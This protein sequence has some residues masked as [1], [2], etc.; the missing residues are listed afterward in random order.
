[1]HYIKKLHLKSVPCHFGPR[2]NR[3]SVQISENETKTLISKID[4]GQTFPLS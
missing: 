1:M 3:I 2:I 4:H